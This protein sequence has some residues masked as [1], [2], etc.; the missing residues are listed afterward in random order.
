MRLRGIVKYLLVMALIAW[1][2]TMI[3]QTHKPLPPGVHVSSVPTLL[4]ADAVQFLSD[5][6]YETPQGERRSEQAIFDA[7]LKQ[8]DEA[9]SSSCWTSSSSMTTWAIRKRH[10]DP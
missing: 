9:Q 10:C 5:L 1:V 7:V 3:W 6:T 8:V 2:G 4:P